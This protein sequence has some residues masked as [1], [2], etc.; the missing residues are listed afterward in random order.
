MT[1]G[2]FMRSSAGEALL[3]VVAAWS[4]ATVSMNAFFLDGLAEQLGYW[5][6]SGIAL[7]GVAALVGA[8]YALTWRRRTLAFGVLLYVAILGVLVAASL[9]C[10]EGAVPYVDA[11]GNYFYLAVVVAACATGCFALTRTLAGSAV[12]LV[13]ASLSCSTVQA[14]YEA[15]EFAMSMAAVLSSLALIVHKNFR[16]GLE[17]AEAASRPSHARN[18]AA[19]VVP[20][21]AVG[22]VALAA[23]FAVIA[24]L[25]PG[26]V[27]VKLVT[28]YR[29]PPIVEMKGTAAEK[30]TLNYDMTTENLVDGFYYTTNDLKKDPASPKVVDAKSMLEQRLEQEVIDLGAGIGQE[31]GGGTRD[32]LDPD[33]R[34]PEWDPMSYTEPFPW[35]IALIVALCLVT[36]ALVAYFVGRRARRV[37]RLKSMLALSP[38]EQVEQV[39]L[40]LLERLRRIGLAPPEGATLSEFAGTNV[41][42]MDIITEETR[43]PF[44]DITEVYQACAFGKEEPT[45]DDV[46]LLSSYYL[47]FWK[48]ARSHLGNFR[49]FFKSFRL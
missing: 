40:F 9:A 42:R 29:K 28:E 31:S 13:A 39:Y 48:G 18:L 21:L 17:R 32:T 43:V 49:Y 44:T 38:R 12:W 36:A 8:L 26:T 41:R 24:P 7:A 23:W 19:S 46:V 33:S 27:T 37:R 45:E 22:G 11:E 6:R 1:L 4:V 47:S 35:L 3:V 14:F 30:P 16:L 2:R 5:G 20:V 10:S 25:D 34:D 15:G